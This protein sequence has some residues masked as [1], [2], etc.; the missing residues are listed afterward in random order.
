MASPTPS[1]QQSDRNARHDD[2]ANTPMPIGD[3]GDGDKTPTEFVEELGSLSDLGAM[4]S[5]TMSS[6][7]SAAVGDTLDEDT[8]DLSKLVATT[9][10]PASGIMR[11]SP[12]PEDDAI[13]MELPAIPGGEGSLSFVARSDVH[14]MTESVDDVISMVPS[15]PVDDATSAANWFAPPNS[16]SRI[17]TGAVTP[18]EPSDIFTGNTSGASSLNTGDSND[19]AKLAS[20][21]NSTSNILYDRPDGTGPTS[22]LFVDSR[23]I[24]GHGSGESRASSDILAGLGATSDILTSD[25]SFNRGSSLFDVPASATNKLSPDTGG[26]VVSPDQFVPLFDEAGGSDIDLARKDAK[27]PPR[28][29]SPSKDGDHDRVS[30]GITKPQAGS[31]ESGASTSSIAMNDDSIDGAA[32]ELMNDGDRSDVNLA[33]PN[34]GPDSHE[35]LDDDESGNLFDGPTV[36]DIDI[37]GASGVNLLDPMEGKRRSPNSESR[38]AHT[39]SIFPGPGSAILKPT[40]KRPGS[41]AKIPTPASIAGPDSDG[42]SSAIF[43]PSMKQVRENSDHELVSFDM[44]SGEDHHDGNDRTQPSGLIDWSISPA[45]SG[46]LSQLSQITENVELSGELREIVSDHGMV[47]HVDSDSVFDVNIPEDASTDSQILRVDAYAKAAA[48]GVAVAESGILAGRSGKIPKVEPASSRTKFTPPP[49]VRRSG[50]SWLGGTAAGLVAGV[51]ISSAAYFAGVVPNK[52]DSGSEIAAASKQYEAQI[53]QVN[54]M[55]AANAEKLKQDAEVA[56]Q[57]A[58]ELDNDLRK[59]RTTEAELRAK[60]IASDSAARSAN[61][62]KL[63]AERTVTT[64]AQELAT[65]KA[66]AADARNEA[67]TALAARDEL[68]Q[69]VTAAETS[70]REKSDAVNQ[71][72]EKLALAEKNAIRSH[73]ILAAAAKQL[74]SAGLIDAKAGE[75][76]AIDAL[77]EAVKKAALAGNTA[78]GSRLRDLADKLVTAQKD[79]E[80]AR[81]QAADAKAAAEASFATATKEKETAIA[82]LTAEIKVTKDSTAAEIE[83][84]VAAAAKSYE[85][86][87]ESRDREI[88]QVLEDKAKDI[89]AFERKLA[90]QAEEFRQ[91]ISAARAGMLLAATDTERIAAE[92]SSRLFGIGSDAY[93]D[94]RFADAVTALSEASKINPSD[95][96]CWYYLGLAKWAT[97]DRAGATEA[98][99]TGGQWESRSAASS[100]TVNGS[101]ERV[102]GPARNALDTYRP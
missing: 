67:K 50:L 17:A 31:S 71:A 28:P 65:A 83:K 25:S 52:G 3:P 6:L 4:E 91:Q 78:E 33:N 16:D 43:P 39:D 14:K 93:F 82:K 88:K 92:R 56:R 98:F 94:G 10:G 9:P 41:V 20:S 90:A 26:S 51:G 15:K 62:A 64:T 21:I 37:D 87:L 8:L 72:I 29:S 2:P 89:A 95:A 24:A 49:P 53:Q 23:I 1:G 34:I 36:A 45:D 99:K 12:S 46:N 96:R 61:N 13:S 58:A 40:P 84:A 66:A 70:V 79:A 19:L 55:A 69:R 74:Q 77:P 73:A 60:A 76:A 42:P 102:Q 97:G 44:P 32:A 54:S 57:R 75:A 22:D 27:K 68:A 85:A 80:I 38:R 63:V 18:A 100:R 35:E 101:L 11:P 48:A 86:K 7:I 47:D 81:K 5:A 59:A 30:F